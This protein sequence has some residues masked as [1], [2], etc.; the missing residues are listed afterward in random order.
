MSWLSGYRYRRKITIDNTKIDGTLTDFPVALL[1]N[2]SAGLGADDLTDIFGSEGRVYKDAWRKRI[3]V[4]T[5]DG[6][7][8]CAV[9]IELWDTANQTAVLHTKVP[10]ISSSADTEIYLYYGATADNSNVGDPGDAAAQGVWDS[11]FEAVYHLNESPT[12]AAGDILDSTSNGN[13]LT[14][15]N[16]DSGDLVDTDVGQGLQFDS[17]EVLESGVVAA[18]QIDG[19][20]SIESY[21]KRTSSGLALTAY[22]VEC[23]SSGESL[24][25]NLMYSL[26]FYPTSDLLYCFWEYGAGSNEVVG[27]SLALSDT[28]DYH[29]VGVT[30]DVSGNTLDFYLDATSDTGVSYSNDPA[31]DA[32]GNTQE[33]RLGNNQNGDR[34][35]TA[36]L[37]EYRISSIERSAAWMKGTY[38]A[39]ADS[40][41]TWSAE[42][43]HAWLSGYKFRRKITIDNTKIDADLT[44][45]P[46]TLLL[47]ATAGT[48]NED[49]SKVFTDIGKDSDRKKI[50][51]TLADGETECYVEIERWNTVAKVAVLHT[52]V[53]SVL[54]GQDTHIYFYWG[55]TSDNSTYVGDTGD[56]AAQNVWDSNFVAVYHMGSDPT[57]GS[58]SLKDATGDL[59]ATPGSME[60]A[61]I[62]AGHA[63]GS[64]AYTFD[65]SAEYCSAGLT[66]ISGSAART[67]ELVAEVPSGF[68]D[69][70]SAMYFGDGDTAYAK[71]GL[72][73]EHTGGADQGKFR[74]EFQNAAVMGSVGYD[75]DS[76]HHFVSRNAA[77][78]NTHDTELIVDGALDGSATGVGTDTAI[79]TDGS[80]H[81]LQIARQYTS[82]TWEYATVKISEVRLSD[83]ERSTAWIKATY[84]SLFDTLVAWGDE[85]R[86]Q[87]LTGFSYRRKFTIDADVIDATLTD[88][89]IALHLISSAGI[90]SDD[91]R[92]IFAEN[93]DANRKKI[94]V[95]GSDGLTQHFVEIED[96]DETNMRAALHV[97]VPSISSSTDTDLYFYF[98][99]SAANTDWVGDTGDTPGTEVWDDDF[100]AV[101][102]LAQDPSGGAGC[103]L[104]STSNGNDGTPSGATA[105]G[106]LVDG[107]SGG[108]AIEFDETDDYINFGSAAVLDDIETITI[109]SIVKADDWGESG[110]G[111]IA[112]KA[113]VNVGWQFYLIED[114]NY[115]FR[116]LKDAGT[117]LGIW[118]SDGTVTAD[119]STWHNLSVTHDGGSLSNDAILYL[120]GANP[121]VTEIGTPSALPWDSEASQ[122]LWVGARNN[123]GPDREFDGLIGEVRISDAIRSAAWIKAT[124]NALFDTM[125]TWS[126]EEAFT[127]LGQYQYRRQI[128]TDPSKVDS[129]LSNFPVMLNISSSSGTG[130]TDLSAIFDVSNES[131]TLDDAF[132]GLDGDAPD[133]QR[134]HYVDQAGNG[135]DDAAITSGA[136]KKTVG[137]GGVDDNLY[138]MLPVWF[139]GD[140]DIQVDFSI[141][142]GPATNNWYIRFNM[143]E[144][145][146]FTEPNSRTYCGIQYA[147]GKEYSARQ[148]EAGSNGSETTTATSDTSG[149]LRITRSLTTIT[150][151]Y[152]NGSSW[153]QIQQYTSITVVPVFP[154]LQFASMT[155]WP[156]LTASYDNFTVNSGTPTYMDERHLAVTT[157]DGSTKTYVEVELWDPDN[158]MAVFHFKAPTIDSDYPTPFYLYYDCDIPDPDYVGLAGEAA[159]DSVWDSDFVGVYHLHRDPS[160]G[161]YTIKDSSQSNNNATPSG[162]TASGDLVDGL[163]SAKA[164]DFDGTDD[165]VNCG[166]DSSFDDISLLTAEAI[167]QPDDWGESGAGRVVQK[168]VVNEGWSLF[169][170]NSY[171]GIDFIKDASGGQ[172]LWYGGTLTVDGSTW[173][174]IAVTH[175]DTSINNDPLLYINGASQTVSESMTPSGSWLSDASA[176]VYIGA[177]EN[178]GADREFD[179][180]IGEVRV[181]KAIRSTAWLKGTKNSL[182]DTLISYGAQSQVNVGTLNVNVDLNAVQVQFGVGAASVTL[183]VPFFAN[184]IGI[185][186]TPGAI[187]VQEGNIMTGRHLYVTGRG[188]SPF[189]EGESL[190]PDI[191]GDGKPVNIGGE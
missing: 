55:T 157:S 181:S 114:T 140:F 51:V 173:A 112:G 93:S 80:T 88:F 184:A 77:G 115:S 76:W 38:Y 59:D 147:G 25:T 29:Y 66:G 82:S 101:W 60:A 98:G 186:F 144:S 132:T 92:R 78:E 36:I 146:T 35:L 100:V 174:H 63:G 28:S 163:K 84:N 177:R 155:G 104:D 180:R 158:D 165:Y 70:G 134:W 37:S 130:T 81:G 171:G 23:A 45:F 118:E 20:L 14:S 43:E 151:Y 5:S 175:D 6:M 8:E 15:S 74:C 75:D 69:I 27:S 73:W 106:D 117:G 65:G 159:V 61:D 113:A 103:M 16:M 126:E 169:I 72:R 91:L 168:A 150:C 31:K 123:S 4:T 182:F 7:T 47:D 32:G 56:A 67:A 49:L 19:D 142:S 133:T 172:G 3:A 190:A 44:D 124:Y 97:K 137:G 54:S 116:F 108:K 99:G 62:I 102:H 105:S 11:D 95:T 42:E 166:S 48:G 24:A 135:T 21:L 107:L 153:T 170:H 136:M 58:D 87:W 167:I 129:D 145:A 189:A 33:M 187:S 109:E 148:W 57:G 138:Y 46:V 9:E 128:L 26:Y 131:F 156:T 162:A 143:L 52:K 89:P 179:G 22:I 188:I 185:N 141:D 90:G 85:E 120:D 122:D 2:S 125:I 119:G 160:L 176:D 149:K 13:D 17:T 121:G 152:W 164:I 68:S 40:L 18:L 53:A 10:S 1:I 110:Y 41:V 64:K 127:W 154:A 161:S 86:Y 71:Y 12:G 30:R 50:A 34:P 79:V 83:V 39:L 111:R 191:D 139:E 94:A 96:W 183:A 178:S